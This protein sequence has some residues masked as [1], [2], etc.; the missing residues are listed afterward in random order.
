MGHGPL[1]EGEKRVVVEEADGRQAALRMVK[2]GL[3]QLTGHVPATEYERAVREEPGAPAVANGGVAHP[4]AS[5][6]Q[7]GE[8]TGVVERSQPIL[9]VDDDVECGGDGSG[10][11]SAAEDHR[12]V[13]EHGQRQSRVVQPAVAEER[14]GRH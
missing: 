5:D 14:Q 12:D 13:V 10:D 8:Q 2:Q 3:S 11:Q 7:Q 1:L 4:P 6:R 9:A